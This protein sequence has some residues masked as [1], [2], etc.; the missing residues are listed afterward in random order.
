MIGIESSWLESGRWRKLVF[1]I[2]LAP[3]PCH[4]GGFRWW[5]V[6]PVCAARTA[7][8]YGRGAFACRRC[9]QL[10]YRSQRETTPARAL[11]QA[12]A[13]RRMFEWPPGVIRGHGAK[14]K[15]LHWA[16]YARLLRKYDAYVNVFLGYLSDRSAAVEAVLVNSAQNLR[17]TRD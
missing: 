7:V 8:L 3:T 4:F 9:L 12:N 13:I 1:D 14:P 16:T 17:K 11:R 6:C 15:H 5:W 10:A 2:Q